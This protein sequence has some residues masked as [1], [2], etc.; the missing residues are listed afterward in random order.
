[1]LKVVACGLSLKKKSNYY[2]ENYGKVQPMP[3][4]KYLVFSIVNDDIFD[5]FKP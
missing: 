1:M 2:K 5:H 4:S 3:L